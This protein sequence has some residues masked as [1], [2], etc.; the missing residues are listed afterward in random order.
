MKMNKESESKKTSDKILSVTSDIC[1]ILLV[2]LSCMLI[3]DIWEN[4]LYILQPV[5]VVLI[6]VQAIR[7]WNK[8]KVFAILNLCLFICIFLVCIFI[9]WSLIASYINKRIRILFASFL[10]LLT[11]RAFFY[12]FFIVIY[13]K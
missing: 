8:N 6:S 5:L 7:L 11:F 1:S 12:K 10:L 2:V 9:F 3:F 4:A 13:V